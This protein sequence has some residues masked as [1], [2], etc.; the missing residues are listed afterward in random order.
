MLLLNKVTRS[1]RVCVRHALP[2]SPQARVVTPTVQGKA[3]FFVGLVL[4]AA[5]LAEALGHWR[6][7]W[8]TTLQGDDLYKQLSGFVLLGFIAYQWRFSALRA[9]GEVRRAN[10]ML[11]RHKWLGALAPALF[12]VHAQGFGYAYTQVLGAVFL[13]VVATGLSNQEI[14]RVRR[15]WFYPAWIVVHVGASTALLALLGYHVYIS[16]AFE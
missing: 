12:Y 13:I 3:Y 11:S 7:S 15:P 14:A 10:S 8:L 2:H 9:A 5:F 6:W 4:L 16:Y 1:S